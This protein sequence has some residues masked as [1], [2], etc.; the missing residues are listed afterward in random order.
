MK[1][2][3]PLF[4]VAALLGACSKAPESF[5]KPSEAVPSS[6]PTLNPE[7]LVENISEPTSLKYGQAFTYLD[8]VKIAVTKPHLP[9][10]GIWMVEDE[11][12]V[13]NLTIVFEAP[14]GWLKEELSTDGPHFGFRTTDGDVTASLACE[15][16]MG[17]FFDNMSNGTKKTY[18]M[19]L[20]SPKDSWKTGSITLEDFSGVVAIWN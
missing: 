19:Q 18:R 14:N 9:E 6:S 12:Q 1:I 2:L 8:G 16:G 4:I 7:D 15:N 3:I 17:P 13:S 11:G 10:Q 20:I 5:S